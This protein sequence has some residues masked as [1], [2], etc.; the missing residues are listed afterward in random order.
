MKKYKIHFLLVFS[1]IVL[2]TAF[3]SVQAQSVGIS[4]AS[5][6]ANVKRGSSYT[7]DFTITNSSGTRLRFSCSTEDL[8]YDEK[9]KR[10]S[11]RSGTLPRSASL[12]TQFSASEVI[13]EPRSS[14]VVKAVITIPKD[15]SGSFYTVPV[16]EGLPAA[17]ANAKTGTATATIGV[18]FRGLIMLT[19]TEG[20][21]YNVEVMGGKITPPTSS[22]E[23]QMSLDLRN[24]G[25]AHTKVRGVYAILNAAGKLSGRGTIGE[26]TYLPTQRKNIDSLW[27]GELPPGNYTSLITLSYNRAGLEPFSLIYEIPFTVK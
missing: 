20:S 3:G 16:F 13:I 19:T 14:A 22:T 21:E 24:R 4:P 2:L 12:W 27:S 17:P 11:G 23:L 6:D 1:I 18:R 15:S 26:K 7:Q 25:T 5:V 10:F 9:G 8:W